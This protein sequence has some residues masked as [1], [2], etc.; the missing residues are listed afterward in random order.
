M[1]CS[2]DQ[3]GQVEEVR[4]HGELPGGIEV[5]SIFAWNVVRSSTGNGFGYG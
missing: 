5:P 3:E 1:N 4:F 2:I